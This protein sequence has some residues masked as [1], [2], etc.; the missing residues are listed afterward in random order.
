MESKICNHCLIDKSLDNFHADSKMRDGLKSRCK[1]CQRIVRQQ[2]YENNKNRE[3]VQNNLCRQSNP[4]YNKQ[5]QLEH[6]NYFREYYHREL[7]V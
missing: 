5:W 4:S 7:K 6:P 3:L 1:D 2:H